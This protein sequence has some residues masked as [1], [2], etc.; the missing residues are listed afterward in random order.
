MITA[1]GG[2]LEYNL[3]MIMDGQT[4]WE[5][6]MGYLPVY[7]D[8]EKFFG[9]AEATY[10]VTFGVGANPWNENYWW[11]ESDVWKNEKLQ[12]WMPWRTLLPHARRRMLRPE[13]DYNF[14][15]LAE[16]VAGII[17]E[18][19]HGAIG[20]HGQA[21][22][23]GPHWEVWMAASAMGPMGAL[24]LASKEGAYFLGVSQDLGSLEVGKLADLMVLN[25][26]PLE[27]IRNTADIRW[28]MQGGILYDADTL[29][30]LW[31]Q[32]KPYGAHPWVD[33]AALRSDSRPLDY[34]DVK[35]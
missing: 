32:K 33:E 8:V 25:A 5:H 16:A 7:S 1:E 12:R 28:V 21:H 26:N 2:D 19:G 4:G 6:P 10:S 18:G 34:W 30:E 3:G 17:R 20:A 14:P 11:G 9:K 22:G 29:D 31:P 35:R 23:L 27:N 24:E 13:T 15:L